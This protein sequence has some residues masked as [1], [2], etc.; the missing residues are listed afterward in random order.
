MD[1]I[2]QKII[3]TMK[4][5]D[6]TYAELAEHTGISKSALQRY[7]T[8][9]TEKIPLDRI[10]S[11]ANALGIPPSSLLGWEEKEPTIDGELSAEEEMVIRAYRTSSEERKSAVRLI[12]LDGKQDS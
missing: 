3:D 8:G 4:N 9:E 5:K 10:V 11:I 7:A 6:I 12:V 2:A 1:K